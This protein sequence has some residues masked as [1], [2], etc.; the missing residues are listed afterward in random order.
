MGKFLKTT[1]LLGIFL[2]VETL[3]GCASG[4]P[5]Y[6]NY[7]G[8]D[9]ACI[10]GNTA[11]VVKFFSDGEAHVDFKEIDNAVVAGKGPFC[12]K[13]G[14]HRFAIFA[15]ACNYQSA[16]DYIQLDLEAGKQY[17][18]RGNLRGISIVFQMFDVTSG[19]EVKVS[20]FTLKV[21]GQG[22]P[23]AVP[24]FIPIKR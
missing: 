9:A 18:V 15:G 14:R 7:A 24:I 13:P 12:M 20:E 4:P 2:A 10:K 8:A 3:S 17:W 16:Q 6:P 22:Q 23:A 21:N 1:V 11:N 19:Q 5:A